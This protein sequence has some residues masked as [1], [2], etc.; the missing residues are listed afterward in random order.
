MDS[1]FVC[2]NDEYQQRVNWSPESSVKGGFDDR[3]IQDINDMHDPELQGKINLNEITICTNVIPQLAICLS[4]LNHNFLP[5]QNNI[6][7]HSNLSD[8]KHF[9]HNLIKLIK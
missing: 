6:T 4:S 9:T 2:R 5:T 1:L 7:T 3:D 8:T